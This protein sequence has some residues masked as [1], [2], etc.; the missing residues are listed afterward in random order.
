MQTEAKRVSRPRIP[1][2]V[3]A[4]ILSAH[5]DVP[6]VVLAR[7]HGI[8]DVS[9]YTIRKNAGVA[10]PKRAKSK[11]ETAKAKK[12]RAPKAAPAPQPARPNGTASITLAIQYSMSRERAKEI[13]AGLTE[14]LMAIALQAVY[15]HKLENA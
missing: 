8:S 5:P 13:F 4:A 10:T 2:D 6:H 11:T 3:R 14:D 12:V 1:E 7:K 15:E 9:V